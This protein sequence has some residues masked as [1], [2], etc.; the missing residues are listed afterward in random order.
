M[1][2]PMLHLIWERFDPAHTLGHR[3]YGYDALASTQDTAWALADAGAPHGVAVQA[4]TQAQGRGRFARRWEAG[5]GDALLLSVLVRPPLAVVP[6]LTIATTLAIR[7]AVRTLVGVDAAVKW[8]NDVHVGGRKLAGVLVEGRTDTAGTTTCV[9]GIGL[10]LDLDP[11]AHPAIAEIATSLRV[12]SGA[13]FDAHHAGAVVLAALDARHASA[14]ASEDL[15][16]PWRR[17]LDTLGQRIRVGVVG[18]ALTGVAEDVDPS[19][20]L[21]LRTDDGRLHTLAAGDVTLSP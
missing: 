17:A 2:A 10:N 16:G 7:D 3:V 1:E 6:L 20:Q 8:P 12:L 5:P 11:S 4:G 14:E 21:L 13:H 9:I 18:G 19:G 15:L